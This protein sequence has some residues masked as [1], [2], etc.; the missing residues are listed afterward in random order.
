ME[1]KDENAA[2]RTSELLVGGLGIFALSQS[3]KVEVML[4]SRKH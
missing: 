4:D 2:Q 3:A 1:P